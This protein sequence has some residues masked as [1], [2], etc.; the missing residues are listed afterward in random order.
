MAKRYELIIEA[1]RAARSI[2]DRLELFE[3]PADLEA[4]CQGLGIISFNKRLANNLSGMAFIKD[5]VGAIITNATHP[6]NRKRF[7]MAHE[8]GH[9]VMHSSYL[10]HNV[11]VDTNVLKRDELSSEGIDTKEVQANAFAAELLMPRKQMRKFAGLD[12]ADDRAVADAAQMF[13]TSTAAFTYR[14]LNLGLAEA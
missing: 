9:H 2:R 7:T 8:I 11:H 12:L 6:K 10:E 5:G 1:E 4:I 3:T 14:L 13:Q